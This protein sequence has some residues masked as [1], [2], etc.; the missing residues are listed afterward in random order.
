MRHHFGSAAA[1]LA[2]VLYCADPN[3]VA[4][5]RYLKNDIL[6]TFL[7][8]L[9]CVAWSAYLE[10]G[11]MLRLATSG[12]LLGL[13]MAA[14]FSAAFLIPAAVVLAAAR[15]WQSD[16]PR[17]WG[18]MMVRMMALGV[19]ALVALLAVYGRE[20]R[21]L[22]PMNRSAR[23]AAGLTPMRDAVNTGS[24]V[25]RALAWAGTHMG[26][27][28]HA[29]AT[30]L[31]I[32]AAHGNRGHVGY[33]FG[34]QSENGWWYYFPAAF[35]VKTPVG[36]LAALLVAAVLYIAGLLRR[37]PQFR[38][39]PFAL[40]T[41]AVAIIVYAPLC[42]AS[43]VNIGI[44]H[45]LPIYPFIF[46]LISVS[47]VEWRWR[48]AGHLAALLALLS[49]IETASVHPH[50]TA[51]FNRIAGGPANG[52]RYLVDSNID[53]GQD[54]KKLSAYMA[55][56]GEKRVCI[57]YFGTADLDYYGVG[58]TPLF[59]WLED[60]SETPRC[61]VAVSVTPLMGAY[62]PPEQFAWLRARTPEARIGYSIYVY[63]VK[64]NE[65]PEPSARGG[66]L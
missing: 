23:V 28:D 49:A 41:A 22:I 58:F 53:W 26:W 39:A 66:T 47:L 3:I 27:R 64:R 5:G 43:R 33:L 46:G 31:S 65:I 20:N 25:G 14:K 34:H 50:Y 37:G 55:A 48:Y 15:E 42:C 62:V 24:P 16:R 17:A 61:L 18:H 52:P 2:L 13:S 57:N 60:P 12:I 54:V 29:L 11:G 36:T 45:L 44:R 63:D 1:L 10:A 6:L 8:F 9:F 35:A 4:Y 30:S 21:K 40:W 32:F 19:V 38:H 7:A 56:R 51:F 59:A